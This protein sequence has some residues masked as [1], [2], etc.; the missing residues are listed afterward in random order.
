MKR[1]LAL[2]LCAVMLAG[3]LAACKKDD[4]P[5]VTPNDYSSTTD[6]IPP[7][8][9]IPPGWVAF[10]TIDGDNKVTVPGLCYLRAASGETVAVSAQSVITANVSRLDDSGDVTSITV[11]G[12]AVSVAVS[13]V[14][15]LRTLYAEPGVEAEDPGTIDLTGAGNLAPETTKP[16]TTTKTT[17]TSLATAES[18]KTTSKPAG[19]TDIYASQKESINQNPN[20]T[21]RERQEAL[22]LLGYKMDA[23]GIFYVE[24]EPWQKQFGF[25]QIY[26]LASPLIQLVYATV[27]I[28]FRYGY[29]YKVGTEGANKG[30]VLYDDS[31]NP[32]Y[33]T[34]R[35]GKPVEKDW[36]IQMWKG[37]YGLVMLGGEIGIYT[38]P[39]TQTSEHYYAAV[40]EEE[41]VMA[42][43]VYQQNLKTGATPKKLLTRGPES[44]WW[45]TGFVPGS[46]F[47]Y[48]KKSEII[49][50]AD[51]GFPN[52]DM[53]G[54]F[55]NGIRSAGF[56]E[57]S[58]GRDNPETYRISGTHIKIAWQYIDQD[59]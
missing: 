14:N 1:M 37:R 17:T 18:I 19:T 25:N 49:L 20:L 30:K 51:I 10:G 31:G 42:M 15:G 43:D 44:A 33:E 56:Q 39:S 3:A 21:P 26:D 57:G 23:N 55:T 27:R 5:A 38:K 6:A 53:L 59:A 13:E 4:T 7:E 12:K 48:N 46:Y 24:H 8:P 58:P 47:E 2:A 28:K 32:L 29:V 45:L 40:P 16:T 50:V 22:K 54:L 52:E 36:M 41:L 9:D 34:D 11:D 35:W